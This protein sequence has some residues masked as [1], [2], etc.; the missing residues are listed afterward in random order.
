MQSSVLAVLLPSDESFQEPE[1][2]VFNPG[3][4]SFEFVFPF[5]GG[6]VHPQPHIFTF[7]FTV[8]MQTVQVKQRYSLMSY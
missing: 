2:E 7:T 4:D 3:I 8:Q 1:S 5:L 6:V